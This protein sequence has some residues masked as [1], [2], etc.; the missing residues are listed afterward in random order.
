VRFYIA[1]V[2]GVKASERMLVKNITFFVMSSNDEAGLAAGQYW[3]SLEVIQQ[4]DEYD[5]NLTHIN[6]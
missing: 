1:Q 3:T 5:Y 2:F 6:Y 4:D